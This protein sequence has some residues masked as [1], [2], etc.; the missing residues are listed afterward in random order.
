MK[1]KNITHKNSEERKQQIIHA[2]LSCFLEKGI[3]DTG[4]ADIRKRSGASTGSIYHHFK[5]KEQ[6]GAAVYLEGIGRYQQGFL[7]VLDQH[8]NAREG[9][10]AAVRFHLTW[11]EQNL[12]WSRFFFQTRHTVFPGDTQETFKRLNGTF[13][14]Q[15]GAWFKHQM[16]AGTI[17]PIPKDIFVTVLLGPAQEFIR[18]YLAGNTITPLSQ[19]AEALGEAAWRALKADNQPL[20]AV[21]K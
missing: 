12:D 15:A 11:A 2:A 7:A 9:V 13:F 6:L 1:S 14:R 3:L 19:A 20:T 17:R 16:A 8:R 10:M 4:M 5:S 21:E 18:H